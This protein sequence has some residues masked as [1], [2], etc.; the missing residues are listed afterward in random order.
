MNRFLL[1]VICGF[2]SLLVLVGQEKPRLITRL[3][4]NVPSASTGA[5][6]SLTPSVSRD[7][8]VIVFASHA[9]NLVDGD[10]N[11]A[12]LDVFAYDTVG[13]RL[14]RVSQPTG[15]AL[16]AGRSYGASVSAD[17]RR[18]V[19]LSESDLAG[20]G[21]GSG[22]VNVYLRDREQQRTILISKDSA[23]TGFAN[24]DCQGAQISADGQRV[25]FSS[26]AGN[27]TANDRLG[28]LN[29]FVV[30]VASGATRNLT[31][32]R[33]DE[34]GVEFGVLEYQMSEDG[35]SV[36]FTY[37]GKSLA[38]TE[39]AVATTVYHW[40]FGDEFPTRLGAPGTPKQGFTPIEGLNLAMNSSG[41]TIV[42]QT[43]RVSST[44]VDSF[45]GGV[46]LHPSGGEGVRVVS[47]GV[48]SVNPWGAPDASAPVVSGDGRV[49]AFLASPL[50][51]GGQSSPRMLH[52]WT[53]ETGAR[54][55]SGEDGLLG[56]GEGIIAENL[57]MSRDGRRL[58]FLSRSVLASG[59]AR[60]HDLQLY[61]IDLESRVIRLVNRGRN[62]QA[63]GGVEGSDPSFSGDGRLLAFSS[64]ASNL[65]E[66]DSNL[67]A[68]VFVY[69]WDTDRVGLVSRR[70][71]GLPA[72][73]AARGSRGTVR[74]ISN[75]GEV[76]LLETSSPEA[77]PNETW[78]L[79]QYIVEELSTGRRT[80]V[81]PS[82]HGGAAAQAGV[83][84][85]LLS[86]NGRFVAFVSSS[87]DVWPGETNGIDHVYLQDL[88]TGRL[89][90][91]SKRLL[92]ASGVGGVTVELHSITVEGRFVIFR[93]TDMTR[94][95]RTNSRAGY[96]LYDRS[97]G[98]LAALATPPNAKFPPVLA[99]E[100][101]ILGIVQSVQ[102]SIGQ[103]VLQLIPLAGGTVDEFP[104]NPVAYTGFHL[105]ANGKRC[106]LYLRGMAQT[107]IYYRDAGMPSA[108]SLPL[109]SE[110][111]RPMTIQSL[112]WDGRY[113]LV[114]SGGNAYRF[115]LASG[116]LE[117]VLLD[118]QG[119][120]PTGIVLENSVMDS[121]G[122]RILFRQRFLDP[123]PSVLAGD[124]MIRARTMA[125][126]SVLVLQPG[127]GEGLPGE[128]STRPWISADGRLAVFTSWVDDKAGGDYNGMGD[129]FAVEWKDPLSDTVD[130]DG[131]G[132]DDPWEI[133]WFGGLDKNGL[134]DT[135]GDGLNDAGEFLAGTVPVDDGSTFQLGI[136][137]RSEG[138]PL[139][140][141]RSVPG[142]DYRVREREGLDGEWVEWGE[143][144]RGDGTVLR[145]PGKWV[146]TRPRFYQLSVSVGRP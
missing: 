44:L 119:A 7:G 31:V 115:E 22:V 122:E 72:G 47:E 43:P 84:Q 111:Q 63:M 68:D 60:P 15:G 26:R 34:D 53:S 58:A 82:I 124:G 137:S 71:P 101:G 23:G 138:P 6:D 98:G 90:W 45:E 76:V 5:G 104:I 52:V 37:G 32:P 70:A 46:L 130:T 129:V 61:V 126:K 49:V 3:P 11:G 20:I 83:A 146:P 97:T 77:M 103:S 65:V 131:D 74:G 120:L 4:P 134:E 14:E 108:V 93:T 41:T 33:A 36:V 92:G 16:S 113:A 106:V 123:V 112:S 141:W 81:G 66:G 142:R 19:F 109:P 132:L 38:S 144:F 21:G 95:V 28:R 88:K 48:G 24:G 99:A 12:I 18:V 128:F 121:L 73:T 143:V 91:V 139:L 125:A 57:V 42:F 145:I 118:N 10:R 55:V 62:S 100:S 116:K 107:E 135:D 89:E 27:L 2:T 30:D 13:D 110:L 105:S 9:G 94:F 117:A 69:D 136:V 75:E 1:G 50:G 114:E 140:E 59:V 40:K 64:R 102:P 67:S 39:P 86:G 35:N 29:L 79:S 17:G 96:L 87:R 56:V 51:A 54:L 8:R 78:G 80:L 133:K 85:A 127:S 25:C